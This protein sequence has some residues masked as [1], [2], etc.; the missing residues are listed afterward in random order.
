MSSLNP[1]SSHP[2]AAGHISPAQ[3]MASASLSSLA[4]SQSP[5]SPSSAALTPLGSSQDCLEYGS[6][7]AVNAASA[8]ASSAA[9]AWKT[10]QSFQVL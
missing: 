10:Y 7:K 2:S 5:R 4:A 1:M 8:A 6:D 9:S 3:Q